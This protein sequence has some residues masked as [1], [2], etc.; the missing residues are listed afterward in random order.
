MGVP[1]SIHVSSDTPNALPTIFPGLRLGPDDNDK[2]S[3]EETVV[4]HEGVNEDET[5]KGWH[6]AVL[7]SVAALASL[8]IMVLWKLLAG[9][10]REAFDNGSSIISLYWDD[11]NPV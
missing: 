1:S 2:D 6:L 4:D 11:Y 5:V 8:A 3:Q 7:L 10:A 9:K